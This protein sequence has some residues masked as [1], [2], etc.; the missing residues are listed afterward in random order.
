MKEDLMQDM[1]GQNHAVIAMV[2]LVLQSVQNLLG[3]RLATFI[4]LRGF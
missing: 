2:K 4:V 3:L 1:A